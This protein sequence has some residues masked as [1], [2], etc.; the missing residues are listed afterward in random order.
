MGEQTTFAR[1]IEQRDGNAMRGMQRW[2]EREAALK[3]SGVRFAYAPC[4]SGRLDET[5]A[6][7]SKALPEAA[8]WEVAYDPACDYVVVLRVAGDA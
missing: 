4:I 7:L 5:M 6:E 1:L 8:V 3:V 2:R